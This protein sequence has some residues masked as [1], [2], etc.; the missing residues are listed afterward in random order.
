M[1]VPKFG[2]HTLLL[3][4]GLTHVAP[5]LYGWEAFQ[6]RGPSHQ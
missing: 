1:S 2:R 6:R 5:S 3:A 4:H